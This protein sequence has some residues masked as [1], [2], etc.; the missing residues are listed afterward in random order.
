MESTSWECQGDEKVS[1]RSFKYVKKSHL[2]RVSKNLK[3]LDALSAKPV[4]PF[5]FLDK[6]ISTKIPV[7]VEKLP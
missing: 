4:S 7:D 1:L 3:K 5:V 2:Q 6:V